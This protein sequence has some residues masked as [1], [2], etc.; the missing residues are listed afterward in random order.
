MWLKE[1][2]TFQTIDRVL[3]GEGIGWLRSNRLK[4]LMEEESNRMFALNYFNK[5]VKNRMM[6]NGHIHDHVMMLLGLQGIKKN[7]KLRPLPSVSR[8]ACMEG[9]FAHCHVNHTRVGVGGDD[10]YHW[11]H[12]ISILSSG[13]CPYPLLAKR[14]TSQ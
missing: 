6:G 2:I 13:D 10:C 12:G 11:R 8:P 14:T 4:K 9:S 1:Y 3:Q 5:C 7:M